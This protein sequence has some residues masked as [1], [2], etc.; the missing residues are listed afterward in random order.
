[1][2]QEQVVS[3]GLEKE[4]LEHF[5]VAES[6][7]PWEPGDQGPITDVMALLLGSTTSGA[8]AY[9]SEDGNYVVG[10]ELVEE[11]L[12]Q[13]QGLTVT[14]H[15][16]DGA[17][18]TIKNTATGIV[19]DAVMDIYDTAVADDTVDLLELGSL[20]A[21]AGDVGGIAWPSQLAGLQ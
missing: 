16:D 10:P 11:M 4:V 1:M 5:G 2:T 21:A 20:V 18:I 13:E 12:V 19:M 17:E 3:Y 8:L 14:R 6:L 9:V 15:V 7:R